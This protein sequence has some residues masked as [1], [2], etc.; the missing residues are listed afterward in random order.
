MLPK[1]FVKSGCDNI[2]FAKCTAQYTKLNKVDFIGP[3]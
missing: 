3:R 2:I 1:K